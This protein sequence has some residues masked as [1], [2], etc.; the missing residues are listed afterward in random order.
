MTTETRQPETAAVR[1][2]QD[3]V[4]ALFSG[5]GDGWRRWT[6]LSGNLG[7]IGWLNRLETR[8]A[9]ERIVAGTREV[10]AARVGVAGEWLRAPFWATGYGSPRDLQAGYARLFQAHRELTRAFIDAAL[11]AQRGFLSAAEQAADSARAA[12]DAG[13]VTGQRLA[14]DAREVE[15]SAVERTQRTARR[16][17]ETATRLTNGARQATAGVVEAA[18]AAA[19][20]AAEQAEAAELALRPVKG[21]VSARGERIYHLPGQPNYDRLEAEETFATETEAQA[22][23][24]RRAQ[25]RGGPA[26]KGNVNARGEKIYHLPGQVNYDRVEAEMLFE[27]EEDAQAAGFRAAQR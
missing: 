10:A 24:Y 14:N 11:E 3:G 18:E 15:E 26:I 2:W 5:Y 20:R 6:E 23:G 4:Q 21:N 17:T 25:T 8:E 16:A 27:T 1:A 12:V 13:T 19:Q 22:A 7:G 9:V